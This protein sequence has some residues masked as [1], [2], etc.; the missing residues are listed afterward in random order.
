MEYLIGVLMA[1]AVCAFAMLAGFDRERVFY[2][3]VLIVVAHYY[4]LFAAMASSTPAL[5][6]ESL[7][8]GAFVILAVAG[9]KK[10]L[11]LVAAAL[12]GHGVFDL[13]HHLFIQNPGVPLWWP[14]FCSSFDIL[15]GIFLAA[16]LVRRSGFTA[17]A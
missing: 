8:A 3:T 17:A 1:A 15:A 2:P 11:W 14:G 6:I 5:T 10:N 12:A 4:V 7:V 16:L 13:F 9:F